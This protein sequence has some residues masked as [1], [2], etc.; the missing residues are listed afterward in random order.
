VRVIRNAAGAQAGRQSRDP[1]VIL[2][3]G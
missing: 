1:G 2:Y 3:F